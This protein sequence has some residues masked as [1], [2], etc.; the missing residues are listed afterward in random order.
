MVAQGPLIPIPDIASCYAVR[1]PPNAIS[2]RLACYQ[3]PLGIE[4]SFRI[5]AER[6]P[7]GL[8]LSRAAT[9]CA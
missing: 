4:P 1:L 9:P 2:R 6:L 7:T 5:A 3:I 8:S